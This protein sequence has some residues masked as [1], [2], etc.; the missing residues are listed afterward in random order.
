M[1]DVNTRGDVCEMH[2]VDEAAVSRVR[3][4]MISDSV[5]QRLAETFDVLGDPTRMRIIYALLKEELCVCD[6]SALLGMSQ[7]AISHQLRVL[8]NLRLVKFRKDGKIVFYSLDDGHIQNL[9][10]EGLAHVEER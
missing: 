1:V 7:S 10:S 4:E 2:Y 3:A 9:L 5:A 6:L 8:R